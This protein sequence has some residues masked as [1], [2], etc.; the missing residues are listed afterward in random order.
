MVIGVHAPEF[1]FEK[2]IDS[3][4]WAAKDMRIDY[5]ICQFEIEFLDPGVEASALTFGADC[6]PTA[7]RRHP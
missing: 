4:R 6:C 5:P 7:S 1:G 3:V 2:Y